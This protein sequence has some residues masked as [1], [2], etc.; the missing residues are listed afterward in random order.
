MH[1]HHSTPMNPSL[2][3]TEVSANIMAAVGLLW[4][5]IGEYFVL[6]E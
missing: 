3:T 4:R 6:F 5:V 2:H 1:F